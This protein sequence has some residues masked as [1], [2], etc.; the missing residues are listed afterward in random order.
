MICGILTTI[1]TT[2]NWRVMFST[3]NV[4]TA[5]QW[6]IYNFH[7]ACA[8]FTRRFVSVQDFW[9]SDHFSFLRCYAPE[10]AG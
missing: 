1:K 5:K 6:D 2:T 9:A 10:G 3:D 8:C 4:P 7:S